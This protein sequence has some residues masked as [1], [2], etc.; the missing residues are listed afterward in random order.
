MLLSFALLVSASFAW[1]TTFINAHYE[2]DFYGSSITAY[3]AEGDGTEAHPYVIND[4][5]HLYNL[6]WLQNQEP[7]VFTKETHFDVCQSWPKEAGT[8]PTPITLDMGGKIGGADTDVLGGAIP[9]IGTKDA[10]FIGHFDGCGSIIKNLWVSTEASDWKEQPHGENEYNS[11]HVGLFGAVGG[12]AIIENFV[13]DTVE[14][15]SHYSSTLGIICG[16]VDANVKNVG[17][18]NAILNISDGA[19]CNSKYSLLGEKSDRVIWEDM[20]SVDPSID[21]SDELLGNDPGGPIKVDAN[22]SNFPSLS[23]TSGDYVKNGYV[24]VPDSAENRAFIVGPGYGSTS[25]QTGNGLYIYKEVIK[26]TTA[27]VGGSVTFG[28]GGSS[29]F[30]EFD[31]ADYNETWLNQNITPA[32]PENPIEVN[33]DFY[34]RIPTGKNQSVQLLT[35]T[36]VPDRSDLQEVVLERDSEGNAIRTTTIPKNSVW[37][38]P[39]DAGQCVISFTVGQMN[40]S[41][42][43]RSIY[44]FNRDEHGNIQNWSETKLAFKNK[45]PFGNKSLAVFLFEITEEDVSEGNEYEFIVGASEDPGLIYFYFL[46]LAGAGDDGNGDGET[47]GDGEEETTA[48]MCDVDYVISPSTNV[49]DANYKNH[50]TL[51]KITD[52]TNTKI[53]Y[54]AARTED[55]AD[56]QD[57]SVVYYYQTGVSALK[58]MSR[59]Q[60]SASAAW[61]AELGIDKS[62]FKDRDKSTPT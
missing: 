21:G 56:L 59:G 38:K 6:A 4:S 58:D 1:F 12:D 20:P 15:K 51:L 5:R 23:A 26:S 10:P 16:Y 22:A 43:Y 46:A 48:E 24:K 52:A 9:P 57:T 36:D 3:F 55:T 44:R 40:E 17:V 31:A 41:V 62:K 7:P 50:N 14:V 33:K 53:Y 42:R 8:A 61:G 32:D 37:F 25:G 60:Q 35:V 28:T 34:D 45:A 18:Y 54:L 27:P 39:S 11:T 2:E 47:G 29:D 30:I 19:T 13:L 49:A